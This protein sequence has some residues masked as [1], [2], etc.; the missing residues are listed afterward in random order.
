MNSEIKVIE[1]LAGIGIFLFGMFE[2][3][4]SLKQ[5]SGG[6]FRKLIRRFTEN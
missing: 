2:L 4:A 5:L 3:E 6:A 1:L